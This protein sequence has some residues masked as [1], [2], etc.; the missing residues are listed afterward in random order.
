MGMGTSTSLVGNGLVYTSSS[1]LGRVD[2]NLQDEPFTNKQAG[3]VTRRVTV[4]AY[5]QAKKV[6]KQTGP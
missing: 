3:I 1:S 6:R 5:Q 4:Q 2:D